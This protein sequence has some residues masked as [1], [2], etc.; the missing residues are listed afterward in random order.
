MKLKNDNFV[1]GMIFA[2]CSFTWGQGLN[3]Y[4]NFP[5][6]IEMPLGRFDKTQ[7][8]GSHI[9]YIEKYRFPR[10]VA[11]HFNTYEFVKWSNGGSNQDAVRWF[12][13]RFNQVSN[14][15]TK[16]AI[17]VEGQKPKRIFYS[18]ISHIVFQFTQ[19]YRDNISLTVNNKTITAAYVNLINEY[20]DHLSHYLDHN[21][22]SFEQWTDH[23]CKASVNNV[24]RF[25]Q[26]CEK[27]GLQVIVTC[28]PREHLNYI[29]QDSWLKERI[30]PLYYKD[31]LYY[32]FHDMAGGT[33]Y[34]SLITNPELIIN[35][36]YNNFIVPPTD[37]HLSKLGHE[38]IAKNIITYI[39]NK[40]QNI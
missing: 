5:T 39:E 1:K 32:T 11:D 24:K 30:L 23:I 40:K 18:E 4:N 15:D 31:K 36:D 8:T 28:W 22:L 37:L 33:G 38:V 19:I 26:K 17:I 20:K 35:S 14:L 7:L 12:N 9:K 27:N 6:N 2:G 3:Y 13:V 29:L 25:L 34:D 10:L 16:Q 21:N